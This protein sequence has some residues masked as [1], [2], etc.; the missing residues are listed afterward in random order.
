MSLSRD[1]L[2]QI[3]RRRFFEILFYFRSREQSLLRA[4]VLDDGHGVDG[5]PHEG[6]LHRLSERKRGGKC[7]RECVSGTGAILRRRGV[8]IYRHTPDLVAVK[9][10]RAFW[11]VGNDR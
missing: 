4:D 3:A 8:G 9:R 10:V 1:L 2:W 5:T 11:P 6:I 7:R